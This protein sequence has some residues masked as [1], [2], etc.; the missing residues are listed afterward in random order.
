MRL[1]VEAMAALGDGEFDMLGSATT[2]G[3]ACPVVI[4]NGPAALAAGMNAGAN[5]LGPGNL[6]N[7]SI[8]RALGLV[9]R[10]VG[11][12]IPNRSSS[13]QRDRRNSKICNLQLLT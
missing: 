3:S 8:G 1:V 10:N 4:V 5:A 9:L 12:A 7:A 2:T 13:R 11:G 6:A